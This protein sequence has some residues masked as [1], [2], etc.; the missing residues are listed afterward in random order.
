M[1]E[2][3]IAVAC[4]KP[5]ELPHNDIYCP[6][7]VGSAIAKKRLDGMRHDD[8][9]DNISRKN[10]SYCELTA[11]YW[12]WKN[13]D[14]D[15]LGLCHYRRFL[16]FPEGEFKY[17]ERNQI[18]AGFL[19]D[20]NK[21]RFGL[22]DQALMHSVIESYDC[23]VGELE[24]VSKLFTPYGKQKTAYL[25]WA[26]HDRDLI[27]V[28]DLNR[29]F[30]LVDEMYPQYSHDLHEYM[31]GK[32]FLG[33]NCFVMK[34][35]LFDEMCEFEFSVL[36]RL[37]RE[38]DLSHYDQIRTR[39]FGFMAEILYSVFIYHLEK[40]GK[41]VKHVPLVYFNETD[42]VS[43]FVLEPVPDS[44]PVVINSVDYGYDQTFI[45]V[46]LRSFLATCN[47]QT[48]YDV[49]LLHRQASPILLKQLKAECGECGNVSIRFIDVSRIDAGLF[50][51]VGYAKRKY[52]DDSRTVSIDPEAILPW[53]L[54]KF[55]KVISVEWHV[56]FNYAVDE[57]WDISLPADCVIAAAPSVID[58]SRVNKSGD[59][60]YRR[61]R[62][63]LGMSDPYSFF[64]SSVAVMDLKGMRTSAHL[65]R[66]KDLGINDRFVTR[67]CEYLNSVYEGKVFNLGFEWCYQSKSDGFRANRIKFAPLSVFNEYNAVGDPKIVQ[68]DPI[69][70]D[71]P[72][73]DEWI[74]RFWR[75]AR[76][77]FFY[78]SMLSNVM[79]RQIFDELQSKSF[80]S[81]LLNSLGMSQRASA[82]D[83]VG[84][85]LSFAFPAGTKR[86][87]KIESEWTESALGNKCL[88]HMK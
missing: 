18:E 45:D 34:R 11:Q 3:K 5:S 7:Q 42:P 80:I 79:K 1:A 41:R 81:K 78:E 86:R 60:L 19:D 40:N 15:Y 53:L 22:E 13:L 16:T 4:H 54:P 29:L 10:Q 30:D 38:T 33:F 2:I 74:S 57:L 70:F 59:Y 75:N 37:E 39:I 36:D 87:E 8:E 61:C 68:Y 52:L 14:A 44:I 26:K 31:N 82:A 72:Q 85:A 77:S 43:T 88:R 35:E 23:V 69:A 49:I 47:R 67:S 71:D 65:D 58:L 17:N 27:N 62:D 12:A 76:G 55:D 83:V 32:K 84:S 46:T 21:K 28:N 48:K 24:D 20:Y 64:D 66:I 25:H 63:V 51:R 50:D 73:V 9:G 6:V 56:L